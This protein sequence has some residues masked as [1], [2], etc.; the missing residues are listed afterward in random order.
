MLSIFSRKRRQAIV[1]EASRSRADRSTL[2]FAWGVVVFYNV[3]GVLDIWSTSHG[4]AIGAGEEANPVMR[5]AMDHFGIGW[6]A[7][8]L[9]LQA[10]ISFMVLW[11][12]HRIVIAL[13][14]IAVTFNAGVVW[15]N[16]RIAGLL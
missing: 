9:G 6:A 15:S 7:A 2:A 5:L 8:K 13:F 16:L 1:E 12:P 11:F 3:I 10:L 14:L 4:I